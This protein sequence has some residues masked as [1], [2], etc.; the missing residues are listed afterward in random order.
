[1]KFSQHTLSTLHSPLFFTFLHDS[2][3]MWYVIFLR[4]QDIYQ[5]NCESSYE[6]LLTF[7]L[8]Y[9]FRHLAF[10]F[11]PFRTFYLSIFFF[12]LFRRRT[13]D[14]QNT[15]ARNTNSGRVENGEEVEGGTTTTVENHKTGILQVIFSSFNRTR[16]KTQKQQQ[17]WAKMYCNFRAADS[18]FVSFHFVPPPSLHP[19]PPLSSICTSLSSIYACHAHRV[20]AVSRSKYKKYTFTFF[21]FSFFFLFYFLLFVSPQEFFKQFVETTLFLLLWFST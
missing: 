8:V 21:S 10:L 20:W 16:N 19:P 17:N 6:F 12:G 1:M 2:I 11:G 14:R 5:F 7:F 13:N 18:R 9:S 3:Y 4:F 15:N